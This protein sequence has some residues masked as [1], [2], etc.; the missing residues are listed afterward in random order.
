[1]GPDLRKCGYGVFASV[2]SVLKDGMSPALP[3]IIPLLITAV[4][5]NEGVELVKEEDDEF[6]NDMDDNEDVSPMENDDDDDDDAAGYTVENA[7]QEEKEEACLALREIAAN[8]S[9]AFAPY[10]EQCSG[11]VFKLV[12]YAHE[13]VRRAAISALAQFAICIGKQPNGEQACIAALTVLVPKLSEVINTDMEMDVVNESLDSLAELL[14][15][16][17]G[18]VL[19]S[20]GHLDAILMCI[21]NVFS[22]STQCQMMEQAEENNT[23]DDDDMDE[24]DSEASEKLIEFAGDVLPAL[25]G[26]MTPQEFAPYFAGM[27]PALLSKTKKKSTIAEKSFGVGVLAVCLE[28]LDGV[29]EPFVSHLYNTFTNAIRDEDSEIR[30]NAV[31]GLGELVLHGRE[32]LFPNYSQILQILSVTLSREDHNLVLD[33]ICAAIARLIVVNINAVPMDQVFPVFMGKLPMREDFEE[34]TWILKVFVYLLQNGHPLCATHLPQILNVVSVI[35]T[36]QDLLPEQKPLVIELF[37]TVA[38]TLPDLYNGWTS[39]LPVDV[40]QKMKEVLG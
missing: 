11:P 27:L 12:D 37:S 14:K 5:N 10:V 35:T 26:A 30:N 9:A 1:M 36:Q 3:A 13:D 32:L 25:G 22:K 18:T 17:K 39:S 15:E 6:P 23:D 34:N 28:P 24:L 29:L 19:K 33:N 20:E 21:R 38:S 16:L 40:Q 31:F 4:E 2:S 8:S 7:Y